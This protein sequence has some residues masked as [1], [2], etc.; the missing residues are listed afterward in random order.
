M[1]FGWIIG[2]L[3]IIFAVWYFTQQGFGIAQNKEESPLEILKK[4]YANGDLSREEYEEQKKE[5]EKG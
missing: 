5:L 1:M 3:L 2:L 4:R